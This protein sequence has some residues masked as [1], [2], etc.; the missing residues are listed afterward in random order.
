MPNGGPKSPPCH[1]LLFC[2]LLC[3]ACVYLLTG[4]FYGVWIVGYSRFH[5]WLPCIASNS[6]SA[7]VVATLHPWPPWLNFDVDLARCVGFVHH[8]KCPLLMVLALGD[9]KKKNRLIVSFCRGL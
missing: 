2:I 9:P 4:I 8:Y 7:S 3:P 1:H 5:L 6:S